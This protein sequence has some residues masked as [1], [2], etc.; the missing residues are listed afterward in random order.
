MGRAA[1]EVMSAELTGS[2]GMSIISAGTLHATDRILGARPLTA[3]GISAERTAA[4]L[5][6]ATRI[7]YGRISHSG[8]RLRLDAAVFDTVR[9]NIDRTLTATLSESGNIIRLSDSLARE[10]E[11]HVRPFETQNPEAVRQYCGG[12][13]TK[14]AAEAGQFYSRAVGADPNFGEAYV[15]WAQLAATQRNKAESERIL[16][17]AAARGDALAELARAR[18]ATVAAGLSG[19]PAAEAR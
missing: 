11:T 9:L 2:S 8:G 7:L 12:L 17:L 15:A 16:A 14:D 10:L 19:N 18:L 6:G 4:L 1:S 13:E 5:S 3:P